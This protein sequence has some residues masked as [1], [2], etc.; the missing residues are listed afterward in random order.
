MSSLDDFLK[1]SDDRLAKDHSTPAFDAV[2][3]RAGLVKVIDRAASTFT[4]GKT[5]G[6]KAWSVN[7]GVVE[8][9]LPVEIGGKST[10]YIPSERFPDALAKLKK[11]VEAGDVDADLEAQADN[12]DDPRP[13]AIRR[14]SAPREGGSGRT[15]SPERKAKF[16]ATIAARKAAKG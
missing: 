7:R 6:R 8:L 15:W 13:K 10:Y 11:A 4:E 2:R 14:Q 12:V 5:S 16:A 3:A 1:L 9:T